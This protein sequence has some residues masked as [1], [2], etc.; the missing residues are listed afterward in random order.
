M[1]YYDHN[2]TAVSPDDYGGVSGQIIEFNTGDIN[3][4]H[5]INITQDEDCE[6]DPTEYFF[7]TLSLM[8]GVQPIEV[9]RPNATI[10]INDTLEPECSKKSI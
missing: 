5:R 8:S 9:I 2:V 4:I 1:D 6:D 7:S 3:Q 10:F